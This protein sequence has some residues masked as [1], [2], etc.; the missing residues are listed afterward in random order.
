MS[1]PMSPKSDS[2]LIV[3]PGESMLRADSHMQWTWG[4]FPESTRVRIGSR[5]NVL[6]KMVEMCRVDLQVCESENLSLPAGE[7]EGQVRAQD[8]DHHSL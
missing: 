7:Q 1:E 3:K 2:E 8:A 4:E 5:H 6:F